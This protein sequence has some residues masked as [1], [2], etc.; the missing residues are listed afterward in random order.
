MAAL[1]SIE[2][3]KDIPMEV[4]VKALEDAILNAYAEDR[5]TR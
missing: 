5:R 4:L 1:R 2:R 3:D